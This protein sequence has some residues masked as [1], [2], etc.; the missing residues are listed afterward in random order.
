MKQILI[1]LIIV[2]ILVGVTYEKPKV[3]AEENN[4][5]Y[6]VRFYAIPNQSGDKGSNQVVEGGESGEVETTEVRT[7]GRAS[8]YGFE[9]CTNPKCLQANGKP[10]VKEDDGM[11]F[12]FFFLLG[13][14]G[15]VFFFGG[16]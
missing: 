5:E 15:V 3:K 11:A 12:F 10:L 14:G 9:S 4:E 16:G 7:K 6:K 1:A 2:F 8:W 13:G